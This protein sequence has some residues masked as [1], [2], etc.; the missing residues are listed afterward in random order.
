MSTMHFKYLSFVLCFSAVAFCSSS[1]FAADATKE[2]AKALAVKELQALE[3]K[4]YETAVDYWMCNPSMPRDRRISHLKNGLS[5]TERHA[6]QSLS[7]GEGQFGRIDK[8]FKNAK[9]LIPEGQNVESTFVNVIEPPNSPKV[10][11]VTIMS[12]T[13]NDFV[14]EYAA[15][16]IA[17]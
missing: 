7:H 2:T 12:W 1:I 11:Y 4:D 8:V 6:L 16:E 15:K 14:I 10:T 13:G 3:A 5:V 9:D 17:R